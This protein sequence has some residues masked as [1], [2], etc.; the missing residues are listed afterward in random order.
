METEM[1]PV[2]QYRWSNETGEH[3]PVL[4]Y[5]GLRNHPHRLEFLIPTDESLARMIQSCNGKRSITELTG[6]PGDAAL[7]TL[8]RLIDEKI[9]VDVTDLKQPATYSTRQTCVTCPN[10]D[11]LIPGLEFDATGT[12]AFCQC[13]DEARNNPPSP[14]RVSNVVTDEE[15]IEAARRNTRSR[16]GVM[17]YYTGGKDS[18]FLLW[19]LAKKLGLRVLAVFWNM[20]YT[21]ESCR[22]NI[23]KAR[24]LLSNV[25]FVERTVS[26]D[27]IK[28]AMRQQFNRLGMPCLCPNVAFALFYPLA[29]QENIPYTMSGIEELQPILMTHVF[30]RPA[31]N[32][33]PVS[34][35]SP[36]DDTLRFMKSVAM[37]PP[38]NARRSWD[39]FFPNYQSSIKD[40][41]PQIYG[42]LVKIVEQAEEDPKMEIPIH[43]R[44]RTNDVYGKWED[45]VKLLEKE[46]GWRMPPGQKNL[47]HTSCRI[48]VVKDYTHFM[49]YK[50][51]R[52]AFFPQSI[53]EISAAV[54]FGL[55][56]RD[57]GLKQIQETG[58]LN[59]PEV[60]GSLLRDLEIDLDSLNEQSGEIYYSLQK[61]AC[62]I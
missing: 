15:L 2:L 13:Y 47:L 58:Y 12:C 60:M 4:L 38:V 35:L 57:E 1:R 46:M 61:K 59:E 17:V 14:L 48:E 25:E 23:L 62:H 28:G 45:V 19:Y 32:F 37:P 30:A 24:E 39:V 40:V 9:V 36:R 34:P 3:G 49:L 22:Q 27:T 51:M 44:L 42:P 43:K 53:V 11:Y 5:Y 56:S 54:Y 29:F 55:I 41:L 6:S 16:F 8:K 10:D 52:T 26:W 7:S 21:N 18:S 31:P 20:P 50:N 33:G